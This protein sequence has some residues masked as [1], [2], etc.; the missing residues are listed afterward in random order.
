MAAMLLAAGALGGCALQQAA[1]PS[2][3]VQPVSDVSFANPLVRQRADPH[4]SLHSDGYYYYTATVPEYDRIEVRRA[5]S[6]NE[7]GTARAQ[8][9]WRKH[10][11]GEMGAHIWAPEMHFVD[12]KWYIYFTAGRAEAPWEIRLYVLENSAANP[13]EGQWVERG[14]LKTGWES[15]SLDATTFTVKGQRYLAWT[16]IAA[17][18]KKGTNIYLAKMDTPTSIVQP[19][20]LVSKPEYAWEKV[21]H[22]VNEGPA[23][24]VSH[25][26]VFL[27]YSASATDANYCLGMVTADQ[28]ADLLNPASWRKSAEPVLRSSVANSQYGP[29]HNAF[30]TTPDGKTDILVYHARNYRDLAGD[31]L[32]NADRHTRAQAIS[33]RPDGTPD[34]GVPVADAARSA[35]GSVANKPLFRD[36]GMDGAADPVLVWNAQ[37]GR[38]WMYYTN[39]RARI[40][41]PAPIAWVHGTHIGIAE[42][43]DGGASWSYVGEA[44]IELP[45]TMGGKD[46]THWAPDVVRGDDGVY[47]MYLTVVPGIFTD[48]NHPRHIVHLTSTDMRN[49]R[50]PVEVKL[51]SKNVIDASVVKLPGGGWRMWYNNEVDKKAIWYADSPDLTTWTDKGRAVTDQAGEG[52]KVFQWKGKWWMIT[53]VWDGLGVYR[54]DDL[55]SWKRQD[56]NLLKGGGSGLDD[57]VQGGHPDVVVSGGRAYLF[58]FTHP[59]RRGPD[60]DKDGPEQRRSSIQ[61]TELFEDNGKLRVERDQ[62]VAIT[63]FPQTP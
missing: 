6:L 61:V 51:G 46:A 16:Q 3:L 52:P 54:S 22:D 7:L 38:W 60:K 49:W 42:S 47:H 43:A 18:D 2:A 57:Q 5:R 31:P 62:P 12:G 9:V 15:F 58:Y 29:G 13:L 17:G 26:R 28:D 4:V 53:D 1:A 44:D 55:S 45:P 10:A 30:T 36:P 34:F 40:K 33:W 37:R 14:Q 20:V 41:D 24:L 39:R 11:T 35:S 56:G 32:K 25:G 27:T 21:G 50:N 19:A 23:A 48:W 63:L 59:D 8:V